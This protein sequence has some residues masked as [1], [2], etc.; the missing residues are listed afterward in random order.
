MNA[1]MA[2]V[3]VRNLDARV[4]E[5]LKARAKRHARSL[6]GELRE[7]LTNSV[8]ADA[9]EEFL[10][11]VDEHRLKGGE[12]LDPVELIHQGREER[13]EAIRR[14]VFDTDS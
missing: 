14:A 9:N 11:W 3:I 2:Q 4:V 13:T 1:I 8:A 12:H 7:I 6:E 10:A 5:R